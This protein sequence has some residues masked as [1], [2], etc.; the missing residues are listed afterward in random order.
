[1]WLCPLIDLLTQ[2]AIDEATP[3]CKFSLWPRSVYGAVPY[4]R[5]CKRPPA[6]VSHR[7][8]L[9]SAAITLRMET[10]SPHPIYLIV[11]QAPQEP[12]RVDSGHRDCAHR[13][14][15]SI[16]SAFV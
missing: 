10:L 3:D 1:M 2:Q 9:H 5:G 14:V 13:V 4:Q 6:L 15:L 7:V 8:L 11:I 16:F 12:V